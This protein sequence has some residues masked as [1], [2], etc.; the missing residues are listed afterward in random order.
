MDNAIGGDAD[1]QRKAYKL[2]QSVYSKVLKF[3]ALYQSRLSGIGY[4]KNKEENKME[5]IFN[6]VDTLGEE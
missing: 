5:S 3:I 2:K 6:P 1:M 4:L